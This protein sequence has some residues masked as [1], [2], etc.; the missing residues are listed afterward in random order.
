MTR[1]RQQITRALR[2]AQR[3]VSSELDAPGGSYRPPK[4]HKCREKSWQVAVDDVNAVRLHYITWRKGSDLVDFV[5]LVERIASTGWTEV[6]RFDCCH[7]YCHLHADGRPS[8]QPIY[9]LDKVQDVQKAFTQASREADI[10][11]AIIRGKGE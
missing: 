9:T 3:E 2:R 11:A 8:K 6:E 5:I 10:R 7:G 4:R 1:R